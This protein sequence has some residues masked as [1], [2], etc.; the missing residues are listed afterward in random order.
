MSRYQLPQKL[1]FTAIIFEG[2]FFKISNF[3]KLQ[4]LRILCVP[5]FVLNLFALWFRKLRTRFSQIEHVGL[6]ILTEINTTVFGETLSSGSF[7]TDLDTR[8]PSWAEQI[9]DKVFVIWENKTVFLELR[10]SG[11]NYNTTGFL[12]SF[13]D[14]RKAWHFLAKGFGLPIDLI[15]GIWIGIE[16]ISNFTSLNVLKM[17]GFSQFSVSSPCVQ[18]EDA[19]GK[20]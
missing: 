9:F 11:L 12:R 4:H 7:I 15:A 14:F 19:P 3:W 10:S 13:Q 18:L 17:C 20:V 1:R 5:T 2:K 8:W 16:T 6:F